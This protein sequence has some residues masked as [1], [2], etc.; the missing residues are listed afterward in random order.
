MTASAV[1]ELPQSVTEPHQS[2][3]ITET[4][5]RTTKPAL[6]TSAIVNKGDATQSCE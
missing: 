2:A 4:I 6:T 5:T 3:L 1:T